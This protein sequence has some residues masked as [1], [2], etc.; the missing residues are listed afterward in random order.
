VSHVLTARERLPRRHPSFCFGLCSL[1]PHLRISHC[2]FLT[3]Q[4]VRSF[5]MS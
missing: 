2:F 5:N 1:T 4:S 3:F